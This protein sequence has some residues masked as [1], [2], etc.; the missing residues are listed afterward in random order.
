MITVDTAP[1]LPSDEALRAAVLLLHR[2]VE[3]NWVQDATDL[4]ELATY[5]AQGNDWGVQEA[6][7]EPIGGKLRA[8]FLNEEA[9]CE[10]DPFVN[11]LSDWYARLR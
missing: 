6:M 9:W 3:V 7:F 11:Y 1:P 5:L 8:S 10:I 2:A 4:E